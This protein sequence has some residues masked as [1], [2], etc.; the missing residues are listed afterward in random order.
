MRE[1]ED[2]EL[3]EVDFRDQTTELNKL[4]TDILG[5]RIKKNFPN[6]SIF[7]NNNRIE[8][9][10]ACKRQLIMVLDRRSA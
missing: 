2:D 6:R 1:V 5:R 8:F 7:R 3:L 4:N 10:G 9:V